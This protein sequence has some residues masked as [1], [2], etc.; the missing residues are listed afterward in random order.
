MAEAKIA[1]LHTKTANLAEQALNS[2]LQK[3]ITEVK[4]PTTE[5]K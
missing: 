2:W 5:S 4:P 1:L 3:Q